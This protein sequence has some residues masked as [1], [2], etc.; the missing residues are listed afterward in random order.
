[1]NEPAEIEVLSGRTA[2]DLRW[3]VVAG[4]GDDDFCTLLRVYRGSRLVVA[5]SG[6]RGPK[7]YPGAV[8]NEWRGR[9][10]DLPY[11]QLRAESRGRVLQARPQP[12]PPP[13][14]L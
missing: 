14:R 11:F 9:T 4:G 6:F 12:M 13:R 8:L 3:V 5:G 10:G 1:M 2:D 7:L